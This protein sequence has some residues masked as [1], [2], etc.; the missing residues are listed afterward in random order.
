M[1]GQLPVKLENCHMTSDKFPPTHTN[2]HRHT[3]SHTPRNN[4]NNIKT[5]Y[6]LMI[7]ALK[8]FIGYR[9]HKFV[10]KY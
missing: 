5:T 8:A 2:R 9:S 3:H 4:K 7:A 6:E 10:V 1:D